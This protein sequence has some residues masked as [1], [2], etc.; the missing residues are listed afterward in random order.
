MTNRAIFLDRDGV[1]NHNRPEN[2][3]AWGEFRFEPDALAALA[4]LA[5]TPFKLIVV[6]NQSGIA[7]GHMTR[8]TVEQI[9]ARMVGAIT[10]AGGRIDRIYLCPH[11]PG[12]GCAC[13]KP[14]PGMLL[15]GREEFQLALDQSYFLG[16]WIDD[17]RAARSAGI[18]PIL[19]LTGR[20]Q[21][22]LAELE[23]LNLPLPTIAANL[24]AAVDWILAAESI[25]LS[26]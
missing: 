23:S 26:I 19:V 22:A 8:E 4:R 7:R 17:V 3:R 6:T 25:S 16:D 2:V 10:A 1:I 15:Q 21:Q 24:A 11:K 14:A 5:Q 13:R 12:A 20:G 18:T 9:H